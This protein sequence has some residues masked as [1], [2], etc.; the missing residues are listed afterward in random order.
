MNQA[1]ALATGQDVKLGGRQ[2]TIKHIDN[3]VILIKFG[4]KSFENFA[5]HEIYQAA[6]D[7]CFHMIEKPIDIRCI[8]ELTEKQQLE[9]DRR[10]AYCDAFLA[11]K[12]L[13][14]TKGLSN[15]LVNKV[16][17]KIQETHPTKPSVKTVYAWYRL[18][19]NDGR[20]MALQVVHGNSQDQ[21]MPPEVKELMGK[22][23]RRYYLKPSRPTI[24][25]AYEHFKRAFKGKGRAFAD[26]KM[27]SKSTFSRFIQR[28][29]KYEVDCARYGKKHADRENRIASKAYNVTMPL[30]LAEC[31]AADFNIGL[32]NDDGT[33]AGKVVIFAI[34]DVATRACLG[35]TVQVAKKPAESAALVIHSLSHSMR[36]KPDPLRYPMGGIAMTYV[37]DNGPGFRAEMTR[38]FMNAIGSDVT[39]CRSRHPEE[40]PHVE[41]MYR[42]WRKKFFSKLS[43]YLGKRDKEVVPEHTLKQ[44]ATLT[45]TEFIELFDAYIQDE[46]HHTPNRGI[47][48]YTPYQMWQKHAHLDE[49]MTI[50]DFDDRL[51]IRGSLKKLTCTSTHGVSHRGQRFH[52]EELKMVFNQAVCNTKKS[53]LPMEVMIDDF[54][55]SAITVVLPDGQLIEVPNVRGI[56]RD[57]SFTKLSS[58]MLNVNEEDLPVSKTVQ[59]I[60]NE[61]KQKRA[62]GTL[63]PSDSLVR[64][65][66]IS[67]NTQTDME[68]DFEQH[69]T[70][71]DEERESATGF[72]LE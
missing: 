9:C 67:Q 50:G 65:N 32:L 56:E 4:D 68:T 30:E 17:D 47:N 27:P 48:N 5:P 70:I 12:E 46:Y 66:E 38:K 29:S 41:R 1:L 7:G 6:N 42:T 23:V 19:L 44:A 34:I 58:H 15:G 22:I 57:I 69:T 51:K 28:L 55:A 33:Y 11:F 59:Q 39:Y 21:R 18:W 35:Y 60:K 43:G 36:I 13:H 25:S 20:D 63:V 26:F 52:S 37:F 24:N 2:G 45:V 14:P 40:K 62:N 72:G 64:E 31:D 54:D 53:S 16:Y 8:V 49:V 3:E 10:S 71:T 61:I